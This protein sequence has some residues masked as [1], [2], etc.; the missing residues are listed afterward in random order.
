MEKILFTGQEF[1]SGLFDLID[2]A[3]EKLSI[4]TYIF[5]NDDFGLEVIN[6]LKVKAEQGLKVQLIV[7][8]IGSWKWLN[9][10][11]NKLPSH[12]EL[13]VFHPLP[14]PLGYWE[15]PRLESFIFINRRNH[16]KIFIVDDKQAII[17]SRNLCKES[18]RWR[19]I[20]ILLDSH[21]EI[22]AL[23]NLFTWTWEHCKGHRKNVFNLQKLNPPKANIYA[24]NNLVARIRRYKSLLNQLKQC[25]THIYLTT[26]YFAPP[27]RFINILIKKAKAG[28]DVRILLP[29]KTDVIVSQ[30]IARNH[31][32]ELLQA[33]VKIYEYQ[34]E[35]LHAKTLIV[36]NWV[37]LGSSNFNQRSFKR[38]LEVDIVLQQTDTI[39]ELK[40]KFFA[41][42]NQSTELNLKDW[43]GPNLGIKI[44]LFIILLFS[45]WF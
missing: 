9:H 23:K 13:A 38:D 1:K 5:G 12:L 44:L 27:R 8:G 19:E 10:Y 25:Q 43:V 45:G 29:H 14:W 37:L 41:D 28:K 6:K 11:K 36:D 17:G 34:P 24:N 33:G 40:V 42:L 3:K 4:S 15:W 30:W 39:A 31:Y 2:S 35:V 7:D 18:L 16:H 21:A 22:E 32:N 26:P 20:S